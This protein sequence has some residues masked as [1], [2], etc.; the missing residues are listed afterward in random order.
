MTAPQPR[1][2]HAREN[3]RGGTTGDTPGDLKC[4]SSALPDA[5]CCGVNSQCPS[6]S[7]EVTDN[8][9]PSSKGHSHDIPKLPHGA[10]PTSALVAESHHRQRPPFRGAGSVRSPALHGRAICSRASLRLSEDRWLHADFGLDDPGPFCFSI[11]VGHGQ[12]RLFSVELATELAAWERSFQRATFM[13][14][15]RTRARAYACSC[16]GEALCFTVDLAWGFTC[17]D[18]KTKDVRWRFKF[19]QLKGSSDDGRNRLKPLFQRPD[20]GQIDVKE[21]EF[22]DLTAVLHCVHAF[23]AAKVASVDP[24]F[25]DSQSIARKVLLL[26]L[27]INY[28]LKKGLFPANVATL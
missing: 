27:N 28:F 5:E 24:T 16:G 17:S 23:L 19:S 3:I 12:S 26:T 6:A 18:G 20:S 7:P 1:P 13:E 2:K 21:L 22:A 4:D 15:Q 8:D 9:S 25:M 14:V 11:Q 10:I